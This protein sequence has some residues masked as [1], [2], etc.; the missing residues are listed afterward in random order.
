[1]LLQ[2]M[3]HTK[4]FS[5]RREPQPDPPPTRMQAYV[6]YT[7]YQWVLYNDFKEEVHNGNYVAYYQFLIEELDMGPY[8]SDVK[9]YYG[10]VHGE[11]EPQT[12]DSEEETGSETEY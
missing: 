11:E 3:F 6:E 10:Q 7:K 8:W 1:M 5:I 9:F 4:T 12:S 2:N